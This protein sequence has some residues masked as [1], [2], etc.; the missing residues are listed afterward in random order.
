M[1]VLL[2]HAIEDS[3]D[4]F[5]ITGRGLNPPNHPLGTPLSCILTAL[6]PADLFYFICQC[7]VQFSFLD[8]FFKTTLSL[9]TVKPLDSFGVCFFFFNT[10]V[11]IRN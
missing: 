3:T 11:K 1:L 7:V 6:T 9:P 4:I 8:L 10:A 5:G 2:A